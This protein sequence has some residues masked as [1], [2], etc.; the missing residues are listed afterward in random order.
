MN[1]TYFSFIQDK[2]NRRYCVFLLS[3]SL[4]LIGTA[5]LFCCY[6]TVSAKTMLLSHDEAIASSLIEQGISENVIA[7]ALT[8]TEG[9]HSHKGLAFLQKIGIR[10]D[11]ET[12]FLPH[13]RYLQ[14]HAIVSAFIILFPVCLLLLCGSFLFLYHQEN[15]YRHAIVVIDHYIDGCYT[16]RLPQTN[17]GSI[18]RL[19]SSVDRLATMLQAQNET[20]QK[21]K[22]FLRNTISDISH[23]LK[24]PLAALSMYQEIME[25]EYDSPAVIRNF[26]AKTGL[27][28]KR[29]EHLIQ[30]LL[31]ITRLD[32]GNVMFEKKI[33]NLSELVSHAISELTARA[34]SEKKTIL[35]EGSDTDTLYCDVSWTSE[36]ISNIVKNALDHMNANGTVRITWETSPFT[37]MIRIADNG[38]G[39]A[40]EEIYHIFKRFY[41]S[42]QP[43]D[44]QGI[45]LGLSLAKS[46]IEGQGGTI[47]LQS[48]LH[49]G[50]T[51]TL[52]L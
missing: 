32:T 7:N 21:T 47:S 3:L 20:E 26:T 51:F 49:V 42:S 5:L 33:C 1:K 6:I 31:K 25:K 13:L 38:S 34:V 23:Q 45:G 27:A 30:S 11:L 2:S 29:M 10:P 18:Y 14:R 22:I 43:S 12:Q 16:E 41:R 19:F 46:I 37:G 48:T 15:L 44:A 35:L 36:A 8:S 24:T 50:T 52:L 39:I 9:E 28:L 17:E 40:P 4:I